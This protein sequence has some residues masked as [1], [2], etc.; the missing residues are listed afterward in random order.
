MNNYSLLTQDFFFQDTLTVAQ[1][2][3]GKLVQFT[4][5]KGK[6]RGIIT[7]TEAYFGDDPASHAACGRTKRNAPMYEQ[8]GIAYVY[9]IYGMYHCLNFVTERKDYPAAVLIRGINLLTAKE[10][11][12]IKLDGPGKLCKY[13][14]INRNHNNSPLCT[15]GSFINIYDNP[16]SV[17]IEATKRIGINKNIDALWRFIIK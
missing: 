7:E 11:E 3:L 4:T 1:T 16:T 10:G 14:D 17:S 12:Y 5:S 13:L 2:L 15:S 8:G 6:F 9:L